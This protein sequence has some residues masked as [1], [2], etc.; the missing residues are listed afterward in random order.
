MSAI[1]LAL[2]WGGRNKLE[3]IINNLLAM[4]GY[5]TVAFGTILF[6]E[7][8]WF[9]RKLGGYDLTAW[10]DPKRM[11]LGA[12]GVAAL[13]IGIGFSFLGMDQTWVC[14]PKSSH[15]C[16]STIRTYFS[17]GYL[18]NGSLILW[19]QYI[20]PIARRIGT[21]GGDVGDELTF[22]SVLISYPILR[23]LEIR[24]TGR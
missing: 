23:T 7:H 6:I 17:I 15:A 21:Y 20:A 10:Q 2:A 19:L 14:F 11:P 22:I 13:L 24:M 3:T 4:I 1:T 9:R 5:W 8:F 12:A 18:V 16:F